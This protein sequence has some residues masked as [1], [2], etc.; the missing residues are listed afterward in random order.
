MKG[1]REGKEGR[2]GGKG[3]REGK[4]GREGRRGPGSFFSCGCDRKLST[5]SFHMLRREAICKTLLILF[6]HSPKV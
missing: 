4:E 5:F 3:R 1:R 6:G 2:E